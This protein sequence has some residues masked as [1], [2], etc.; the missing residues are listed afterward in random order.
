MA[1]SYKPEY[2]A[3][4][5]DDPE[6]EVVLYSGWQGT[7]VVYHVMPFGSWVSK[8]LVVCGSCGYRGRPALMDRERELHRD[9]KGGERLGF[10]QM[11]CPVCRNR[12]SELVTRWCKGVLKSKNESHST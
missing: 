11:E 4:Y 2:A 6:A 9:M 5:V 8:G 3:V 7:T 10:I 1:P 12:R